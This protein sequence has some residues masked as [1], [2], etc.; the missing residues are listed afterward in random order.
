MKN[1]KINMH[2]YG[3]A[4]ELLLV[5]NITMQISNKKKIGMQYALAYYPKNIDIY[6]QMYHTGRFT[7]YLEV[8]RIHFLESVLLQRD[9]ETP[10][11]ILIYMCKCVFNRFIYDQRMISALFNLHIPG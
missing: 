6:F 4:E 8:E 9:L 1:S 2:S 7:K 3:T 10:L 5:T 11:S